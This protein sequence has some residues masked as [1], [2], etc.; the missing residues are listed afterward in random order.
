MK[1]YVSIL[2]TNYKPPTTA[3]EVTRAERKIMINF[4]T[5]MKDKETGTMVEDTKCFESTD[6]CKQHYED[7]GFK[8]LLIEDLDYEKESGQSQ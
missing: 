2:R 8:V 5:L 6:S 7:D 4:R 1:M 3:P